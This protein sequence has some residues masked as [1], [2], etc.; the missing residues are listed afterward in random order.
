MCI[1]YFSLIKGN[2]IFT[3]YIMDFQFTKNQAGRLCLLQE[4]YRYNF[5]KTNKSGSTLWRC[6]NRSCCSSTITLDLTKTKVLR[7]SDKNPHTCSP[8]QNRN[9]IILAI[10]K[11]KT[12]VCENFKPI[13]KIYE[14][15]IEHLKID[16]CVP[17]FLSVKD[18]LYRARKKIL[19]TDRLIFSNI[20]KV[21]IPNGLAK[22]FLICEDGDIEKKLVFYT[23]LA[24][25]EIK[26]KH[27]RFYGDGTFRC[28]PSP[29]NQLYTI[30]LDLGS[31]IETVNVKPMIYALLPNKSERTYIR[32]FEILIIN[33]MSRHNA[34]A[35]ALHQRH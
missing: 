28:V 23:P 22:K 5:E 15:N 6:A 13:Q 34:P 11:T 20:E 7:S 12:D 18:T 8:D 25:K 24:K 2:S 19:N 10:E 9:R 30:H 32:L 1:Q 31:T 16:C 29:F 17:S 35:V 14:S 33:R 27:G 26:G 4:G 21:Y 3:K